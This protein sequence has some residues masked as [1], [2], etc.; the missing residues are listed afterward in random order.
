LQK[1]TDDQIV[2]A[3]QN[4]MFIYTWSP[5]VREIAGMVEMTPGG[6]QPRLI[7]L[8]EQGRIVHEGVR[9]IRVIK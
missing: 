4:Y 7:D 5:S 9:Q 8:R 3:I 6:M 1:V 2:E